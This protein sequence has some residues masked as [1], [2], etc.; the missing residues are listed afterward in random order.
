RYDLSSIPAM[1]WPEDAAPRPGLTKRWVMVVVL[2]LIG[3]GAFFALFLLPVLALIVGVAV[4]W[5][6]PLWTRQERVV[7]T[8]VP[9]VG[10]G[11]FLPLLAIGSGADGSPMMLLLALVLAVAGVGTLVWLAIRGSRAARRVDEEMAAAAA[12]TA[13]R[14]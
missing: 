2:P 1:E 5:M 4:L 13:S 14:R 10:L 3:L 7:G 6:S 12:Q 9:A 8:V 11:A